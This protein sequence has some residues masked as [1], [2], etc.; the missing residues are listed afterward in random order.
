LFANS[1]YIE[2]GR[3]K[4]SYYRRDEFFLAL[5]KVFFD[6]CNANL[7]IYGVSV[8]KLKDYSTSKKDMKRGVEIVPE[9]NSRL[10]DED[11]YTPKKD[12]SAGGSAGGKAGEFGQKGSGSVSSTSTSA[13]STQSLAAAGMSGGEQFGDD[14]HPERGFRDS[15]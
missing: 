2:S 5:K 8:G 13:S 6:Q 10:H 9:E 12:F 7:P 4:N 15:S 11:V 14:Y 3:A 1:K